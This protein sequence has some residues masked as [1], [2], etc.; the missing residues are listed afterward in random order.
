MTS[1]PS[2]SQRIIFLLALPLLQ[3]NV[4][5]LLFQPLTHC[6]S[7]FTHLGPRNWSPFPPEPLAASVPPS[8]LLILDAACSFQNSDTNLKWNCNSVEI[9][10]NLFDSMNLRLMHI[11]TLW[12]CCWKQL[13]SFQCNGRVE[14]N[15]GA[16]TNSVAKSDGHVGKA[17]PGHPRCVHCLR[18]SP[19]WVL[20]MSVTRR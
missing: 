17:K 7:P 20:S 3:R 13:P 8:H 12:T 16:S 18:Y 4:L 6:R 2:I 15:P 9:L 14:G 19:K 10:L 5:L 1:Q 11:V